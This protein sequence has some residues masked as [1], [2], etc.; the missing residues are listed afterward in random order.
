MYMFCHTNKLQKYIYVEELAL[1]KC[2]GAGVSICGNGVRGDDGIGVVC[3]GAA[4]ASDA[5]HAADTEGG[6]AGARSRPAQ[7]GAL[8]GCK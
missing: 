8:G 5:E 7:A 6:G 3:T 4:P 1:A 2:V